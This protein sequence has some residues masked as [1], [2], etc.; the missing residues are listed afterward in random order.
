[1]MRSSGM[2]A[3]R[4]ACSVGHQ[5]GAGLVDGVVGDHALCVGPADHAV[6]GRR[7]DDLLGGEGLAAP[8]VRVGGGDRRNRR[9]GGA[10]FGQRLGR[11]QPPGR[12]RGVFVEG[13][14]VH[15]L[16]QAVLHGDRRH[17]LG[18]DD[19]VL[20]LGRRRCPGQLDARGLGLADGVLRL[21]A[22]HH[23]DQAVAVHDAQRRLVDAGRRRLAA[24]KAIDGARRQDAQPLRKPLRHP[25][26]AP[27]HEIDDIERIDALQPAATG[28]LIGGAHRFGH[29]RQRLQRRRRIGRAVVESPRHR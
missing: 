11:G 10:A 15:R 26:V 1:M 6:V 16:E 2:P 17:M 28:I 14:D 27:R 18:G 8:G 13:I 20:R 21:A 3:S 12:G 29:Q 9:I 7:R 25:V 24:D 4:A 23:G 22:G 19:G 5:H